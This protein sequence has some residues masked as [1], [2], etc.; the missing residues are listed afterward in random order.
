MQRNQQQQH[1]PKKRDRKDGRRFTLLFGAPRWYAECYC[2]NSPEIPSENVTAHACCT[3]E[4]R[5]WHSAYFLIVDSERFV[6][7]IFIGCLLIVA[8]LLF[9]CQCGK[10]LHASF[11]DAQKNP[12]DTFHTEIVRFRDKCLGYHLP[13]NNE[14]YQTRNGSY[15]VNNLGKLLKY[16]YVGQQWIIKKQG[17]NCTDSSATYC[18]HLL[19]DDFDPIL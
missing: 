6:N 18:L 7:D 19:E 3:C 14:N 11:L 15:I 9:I 5:K 10:L 4:P 17:K 1:A 12:P 13:R 16:T 2:R 8:L